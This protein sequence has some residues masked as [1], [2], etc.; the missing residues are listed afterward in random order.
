M[1]SAP[2][3]ESLG[4]FA[5]DGFPCDFREESLY[6]LCRYSMLRLTCLQAAAVTLCARFVSRIVACGPGRTRLCWI[7]YQPV[8][9]ETPRGRTCFRF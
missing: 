5:R 2:V 9:R 3:P 4:Q 7:D 1:L 6:G 8:A